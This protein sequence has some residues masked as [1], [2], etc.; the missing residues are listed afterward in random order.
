MKRPWFKITAATIFG[1][2]VA[3]ACIAEATVFRLN[4]PW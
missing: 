1:S 2:L 4:L 3:L